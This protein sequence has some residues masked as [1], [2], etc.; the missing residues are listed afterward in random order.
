MKTIEYRRIPLAHN[1]S[2]YMELEEPSEML[3]LN[4]WRDDIVF[5]EKAER[6]GLDGHYK[7]LCVYEVDGETKRIYYQYDPW[8]G[9]NH[10]SEQLKAALPSVLKEVF[11]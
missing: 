7:I 6:M 4:K 2:K 3:A 5:S 1:H 10:L 9:V 11:V 8:S